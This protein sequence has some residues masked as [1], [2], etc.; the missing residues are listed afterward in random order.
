MKRLNLPF[1]FSFWLKKA[2]FI[3]AFLL[4]IGLTGGCTAAD[5]QHR[6]DYVVDGD[7]LILDNG[8][9]VR[10][11]GI[12]TPEMHGDSGV[13]EPFAVDAKV[14]LTNIIGNKTVSIV[15]GKE[16]KDQ[17][18]RTLAY[19]MVN[20]KQD[21]QQMMLASGYAYVVAFP[22]NIDRLSQYMDAEKLARDKGLGLWFKKQSIT[23]TKALSK[24]F[25]LK[26]GRIT[27]QYST[28]NNHIFKFDDELTI[29]IR[30]S[31]WEKY[32]NGTPSNW[33]GEA[34]ELRG[35]VRN[36]NEGYLTRV[37]HPSMMVQI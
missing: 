27:N 8:E 11:I 15:Q 35:W 3:G 36:G 17:Y 4:S 12:N 29:V 14:A 30:L 1:K 18:G 6:V 21:V 23:S 5:Q 20:K 24:G 25:I 34:V 28:E 2:P 37:R 22:P 7:T 9:K 32:W 16:A 19:V 26:K 33:V 13:A 31:D 10:L